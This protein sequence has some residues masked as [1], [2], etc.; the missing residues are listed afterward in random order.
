[1]VEKEK[2]N[3]QTFRLGIDTGGTFTDLVMMNESSGQISL[4]KMSSTP[5]DPAVAFMQVVRRSL[6]EQ[7]AQPGNCIHMVHGTTVATNTIIEGKGARTAFLVTRGFRDVLEIGRQIRPRLYDLF[8]DKPKP[9]VPRRLCFEI[10]ERLD[11][12][13]NVLLP[14]DEMAVRNV[15]Q[16]IEQQGVESIVICLLHAYANSDHEKRVAEILSQLLPEIPM[17]LSADLCSEMREYYRASTAAVNA[18]LVPVVGRYVG[19]LENQLAEASIPNVLHLMTSSG[20]IISSSVARQNPV[21]LVES[22][23]AA[24]VISAAYLGGLAGFSNVISFDMGGTTAKLGLVENGSPRVARHFEVGSEASVADQAAGY[25]VRTPVVDLVEIGAGGGSIAW[26][27]DGGALRV[28]P[29]SAGAMPGPACYGNGQPAPTISDAN[30]LLGRINPD[31]FIGGEMQL[32]PELAREAIRT[33]ADPLGMSPVDT[34]LGIIKIADTNMTEA[35]RMVSVQRGFDP[36][37]FILLAFGGAGPLHAAAIARELQIPQVMI[38]PHPGVASALGLLVGD[39]K[40]DFVRAYLTPTDKITIE[41]IDNIL[42][43]FRKEGAALLQAEHVAPSDMEFIAQIDMRFQG[44]SHELTIN[45]PNPT[46]VDQERLIL[47]LHSHF[48]EEHQRVHG[49]ADRREPS[50]LVNVRLTAIGKIRRPSLPTFSDS[51]PDSSAAI[52]AQRDVCF[53]NET[54]P[55]KCTI[56]NREVLSAGN[57]I[58]GPAIVEE[59]DSTTL[60]PPDFIAIV[61]P[62]GNMILS[63]SNTSDPDLTGK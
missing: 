53:P 31:N 1:M 26:I 42:K 41:T 37:E 12:G 60:I 7:L 5:A 57:H 56:Y 50:E 58:Q 43:R 44:Q 34:A 10:P 61:D 46:D 63:A 9:L 2:H 39:I 38:P 16:L 25:P 15:A 45:M 8:C 49:F 11:S 24:G 36:R 48:C 35:A 33:V 23:P 54:S 19:R 14:L 17:T 29:R 47:Q 13:G 62:T 55:L 30:L 21:H 28:G 51:G 6:T 27:D 4:V 59:Y 32:D 20:G 3:E 40:H 18:L 22:G 52:T